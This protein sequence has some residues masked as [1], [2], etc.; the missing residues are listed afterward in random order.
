[1]SDVPVVLT[2][3][4]VAGAIMGALAICA[5]LGFWAVEWWREYYGG[6]K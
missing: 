4:D 2:A 5:V 3:S 6:R 1:M